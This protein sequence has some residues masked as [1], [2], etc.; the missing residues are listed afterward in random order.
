MAGYRKRLRHSLQPGEEATVRPVWRRG[1][2]SPLKVWTVFVSFT[3]PLSCRAVDPDSINPDPD[4][5]FQV[6][7]DP[8]TDPDPG[9]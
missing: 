4:P 9:F 8:D 7:P 2:C 1:G 5:A 3:R 6:N